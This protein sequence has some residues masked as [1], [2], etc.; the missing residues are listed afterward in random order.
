M[1]AIFGALGRI[2]NQLFG[3]I[4]WSPPSWL[5]RVWHTL[6]SRPRTIVLLALIGAAA[7]IGYLYYQQLPKPL[8]YVAE[9][10]PPGLT[11]IVEENLRPDPLRI[12]FSYDQATVAGRELGPPSV[13]ALEMLDKPLSEGVRL[14]PAL[15]GEWQWESDRV[16][17]FEPEQDWPAGQDYSA[18]FDPTLFREGVRLAEHRVR[19]TTPAFDGEL[20]SIEF[21]QDP[22]DRKTRRVVA[23][24]GFTHAVDPASLESHLRLGMRP[25]GAGIETTPVN[26]GF[27]VSYSKY[28]RKAYIHSEPIELPE[29]RNYMRLE[30][31]TGVKS[32]LGAATI[33][34]EITGEVV[35]P[36][37]AS[38]FRVDAVNSRIVRN[39]EDEPEQ[40]LSLEFTDDIT[41]E[42]VHEALEVYLLPERRRGW[43]GPRE[44]DSTVL[45]G[46]ERVELQPIPNERE[47]EKI[48][49]FRIDVAEKR[50]LYLRLAG[51]LR[52][53]NEFRMASGYDAVL[54]TPS[55]PRELKITNEGS[56][57]ALSG[58]HQ[59]GLLSRNLEA[60]RISIG[61]VLPKQLNHLISQSYGDI[62]NPDF[63][64]YSFNEQNLT[65]RS[66][67]VIDL[68]MGHP[69]E[70]NYA[71]FDLSEY[72]QQGEG[73]GLFFVT[74]EGW[75][76]GRNQRVYGSED[77]RL[78]LVSDLGIIAKDNADH[79]HELFVQSI[80]DGQ[81][82]T[83]ATVE[84]LGK[85]GLPVMSVVT[86]ERG[87]ASL[88]ST[89]GLEREKAPT[90]YLV[91]RGDDTSFL[92]FNRGN[93]QLN[94][95][96][97]DV[98]GEYR[99]HTDSDEL[100]AFLF[101]D[102][103]I[104]R[105][106]ETV[107]LG[108]I[109]RQQD[110]SAPPPI[111]LELEIR[112]P[113]GTVTL[114]KKLTLPSLG[115]F[116]LDYATEAT[117]ET[118]YYD[119]ALYLIRGRYRGRQIGSVRFQVEEF[120][121][122]RMRI[123]SRILGAK[124]KGWISRDELQAEV[125]L[126]NLFGTPAQDRTVE[127]NITLSP[128]GFRFREYAEY[129]FEDPLVD[130]KQT[131]RSVRKSLEPQKTDADGL[132]R[133]EW[134]L[135]EY[136]QGTYRLR[137]DAEGFEQGGGRSVS[138]SSS[139]LVSPLASLV[140]YK[141]DGK[142]DYISRESERTLRFIAIDNEL[143]AIAREGLTLRR[144]EQRRVSTLVR[145]ADGTYKYQTVI[146][147]NLLSEDPFAVAKD[148]SEYR[149][150]TDSPG[151]FVLELVDSK[152]MHLARIAFSVVGH[153]NLAGELEKN[154]ELSLKLDRADYRPGDTIEM[155]ITAP[156]IGSGLITIESDR[157]HAFKWFRSTT[158]STMQT[159]TVPP[160]LEGNAYV[161]VAFVRAADSSEIFTSPLSYAV[162]PF[163]IDR[164]KRQVGV[165]LA[166]P[167]IARPGKIMEIGYKSSVSSRMVIFAV[168]EGIL[169]VADYRTP[170]PLDH[171]L[172]KRALEVRT[173]QMLDLIL[174]EYN[175]IRER[176]ASGG[177]MP[178][179]ASEALGR[180]LNPFARKVEKPAVFW[181]GIV[182]AGPEQQSVGFEIPETFSGQLRVMAVA[183]AD[184]AMGT[185]EE[186]TLVRGPFVI[187]PNVL[188]VA[189]PGDEF[190]VTVGVANMVEGSG[191][192]PEI[193]LQAESSEQLQILGE[194]VAKLTIAEGSEG[195][196]DFRVKALARPGAASIAFKATLGKEEGR[197]SATLSVRP[198]VPY[199]ASFDSGYAESGEQTVA[200]PRQLYPQLADQQA[201]ASASPLVLVDGLTNY[202]ENFPHGCTEQ[203]VSQVFPLIGLMQHTGYADRMAQ[204]REKVAVL[205]NKLRPRQPAGRRFQFLARW[206]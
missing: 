14:K 108:V 38:F 21:Y 206:T 3:R 172:K 76:P 13:A 60:A 51:G 167:E 159:I 135:K 18:A 89:K 152:G 122:D 40:I 176:S 109:V 138:A 88:P 69:A 6:R 72:L 56:L 46:A 205:I 153:G 132:A 160:E 96:R 187:S 105:P 92:P 181:S 102:R 120:Q 70:A 190:I 71:S 144:L 143:N 163:T 201:S 53:I 20:E 26:Y 45:A 34:H 185:A 48:Y 142:L 161:N 129:R 10:T 197:I 126:E 199:M 173:Q 8:Q 107:N 147:E 121:P 134:S 104:Y 83:G 36:D 146:K 91:R 111:P 73:Y 140:G 180:N 85:N 156:Y 165:T 103:G 27:S 54:Q 101:S 200:L 47:A 204:T 39:Q 186:R 77:K 115:F 114:K 118:G 29:K 149:L 59:F 90:V 32:A 22:A 166:V 155:N 123:T 116:D 15:A 55:Y 127:A 175:L 62:S 192:K 170:Q 19:F 136:V 139:I 150:P 133:F 203:V 80:A 25:S 184:E 98:G 189:A 113:R 128:T 57:L 4:H 68:R 151:D 87:H 64:N 67:Q 30:L 44:V 58:E 94:F 182:E 97:F 125:R 17:R 5:A 154:A 66:E 95:S 65:A 74:V 78:I 100:N 148:G 42:Q 31:P 117:A 43:Q 177:G 202:L 162:A 16:L 119:A 28:Q 82:V 110:L 157:V 24:L 41:A 171:F 158:T 141:A 2:G 61:R 191:E 145:Q 86:D 179:A 188:T 84:L 93:R 193:I 124:D 137:F 23:T 174:P 33:A 81:P 50:Q 131:L 63:N 7:Y 1:R 9:A 75:D 52:S 178:D 37:I 169:Q 130:P 164:S 168:D 12:T 195:K 198:A 194:A 99:S 35:I 79:S 196:A 11:R 49:N 112:N 183:V 106:G